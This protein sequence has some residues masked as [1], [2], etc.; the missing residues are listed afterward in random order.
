[1]K[2]LAAYLKSLSAEE[3]QAFAVR[4]NT[5]WAHLRNVAFSGKPCGLELA[6]AIERESAGA[7]PADEA[8][9]SLFW[10]R[11]A[12]GQWPWHS[13]GR[14]LWNPDRQIAASHAAIVA[15]PQQAVHQITTEDA[16]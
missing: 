13:Q 1:M 3:R 10:C 16:R 12:D 15:G 2:K 8:K 9:P 7:V 4:C 14:P 6:V 5:T 11:I